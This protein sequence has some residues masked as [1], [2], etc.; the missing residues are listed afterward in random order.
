VPPGAVLTSA[1]ELTP[2]H[3]AKP[4]WGGPVTCDASFH[5]DLVASLLKGE[6]I[7]VTVILDTTG[8]AE[9]AV[10]LTGEV[11]SPVADPDPS[12]NS[13]TL[14]SGAVTTPVD[15]IDPGTSG[16]LPYTGT[17]S[18]VPFA[19]GGVALLLGGLVLIGITTHRGR[20]RRI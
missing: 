8:V 19:G 17:R 2:G 1:T 12:N 5:C 16:E 20:H 6:S 14:T 15:P 4:T 13:V 11:S 7:D 10:S 3:G 18:T 9:G